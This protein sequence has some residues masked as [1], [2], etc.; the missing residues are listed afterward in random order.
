MGQYFNN[1]CDIKIYFLLVNEEY[2]IYMFTINSAVLCMINLINRKQLNETDQF[3]YE[4][5]LVLSSEIAFTLFFIVTNFSENVINTLS[6]P[7]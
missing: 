1:Y 5:L 4:L 6:I 7:S 3:I 2:K